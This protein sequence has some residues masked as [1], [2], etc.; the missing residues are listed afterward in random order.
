M[1]TKWSLGLHLHEGIEQT[2]RT[3]EGIV[4]Y[5]AEHPEIELRDFNF[6]NDDVNT[7]GIPPWAGRVDAIVSSVGRIKGITTWL[8]RGRVPI[9]NAAGDLCDERGI[10]SVYTDKQSVAQAA[11]EHFL[12]LGRSYVGYV[13]F[14]HSDGSRA[15]LK[16]VEDELAKHRL[17][18]SAYETTSVLNGT[19]QDFASLDDVEP[20]LLRLLQRIKKPCSILC[21]NDRFAVSV[22]RIVQELGLSIPDDVAVMGTGDFD[23]ARM[24]RIPISSIR[25]NN[26]QIGYE[27]AR[28]A[29]RLIRGGRLL[30][31]VW[32]VPILEMI[33]RESTIGKR[34]APGT[35]LDRALDY[36]QKRACEG[37]R[38]EDVANY[39]HM[40]LRTFELEFVRAMGRP[41]GEEIRMTRLERAKNLLKISDLP[42]RQIAKLVGLTDASNLNRFFL[43]WHKMSASEFREQNGRRRKKQRAGLKES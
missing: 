43:R 10:V 18:L 26:E 38:V 14:R 16:S 27:S 35:D 1:P 32:Q 40:P 28:I 24:A 30:K 39:V 3:L 42:L 33:A 37:I 21:L 20:R 34:R 5:V 25:T 6:F 7:S 22:C 8:M 9:V 36:I 17:R 29:H 19:F 41:P 4:K 11:V 2:R 13:G 23:I 12:Q 31:R 15:R